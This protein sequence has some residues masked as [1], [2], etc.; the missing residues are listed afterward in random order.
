MDISFKLALNRKKLLS[1]LY[2]LAYASRKGS[3]LIEGQ[4]FMPETWFDKEYTAKQTACGF[5]CGAGIPNETGNRAGIAT[6]NHSTG[7]F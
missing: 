5:P 2:N 6:P 3:S 1:R 4:L 7:Q